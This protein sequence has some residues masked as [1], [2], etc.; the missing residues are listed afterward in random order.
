MKTTLIMF[1]L[2]LSSS[3]FISS[4]T[5]QYPL[6]TLHDINYVPDSTTGWPNSPWA[7]DTVR[8]Q[9]TVIVRPLIDSVTDR[10]TIMYAPHA[11]ESVIQTSDGSPW[12][13]LVIYQGDTNATATKFDLCDTARTYEFTG[14]VSP[15]PVSTELQLITAPT[16]IPVSLVSQQIKRPAPVTLTLDSCF[17]ADGSFNI[18]LRK[19]NNMYVQIVPDA[20]HPAIITSNLITNPIVSTAGGFN[21]DNG[22]GLMIQVY[23]QSRYF[24]TSPYYTIRPDYVPPPNGT[25]LSQISGLLQAYTNTWEI[26]P[27]YPNDL[28]NLLPPLPL[29]TN[30]KRNPGVVPQ[31][32]PATVSATVVSMGAVIQKVQLYYTVN[33]ILDSLI[34]IKGTGLDSTTWS[35]I[36]PGIAYDS[37]FVE[38]Y[39]KATDN[40]L[41]SQTSPGNISN[42]RY[43]YFILN[44]GKPFTI[45]HVRYSPFGSGQS[46]YNGY[47]V[48]VSG[49]VT[50][51]TSDIPGNNAPNPPR[52]FI[53]NGSNPWSGI[54]LGYKG[55]YGMNVL[56]L[57]QGDLVI[58][59]GTPVLA[60]TSGI[61]LD[62][63]T[64]LTVVSHNNP[65]PSAH[66][67][68][69]GT[70]GYS[71]LGTVAAEQ[72]NSCIV[73]YQTVTIDIANADG[74]YNYGESYCTDS[75]GGNHTRIIWSDGRTQFYAGPSAVV[76]NKG[77]NFA[78]ITGILGYSH[79][80]YK[81]CPRNN[82]DIV[83]Y[84][85]TSV[86]NDNY[87]IPNQY[88][89]Y[90]NFPNPFNPSTVIKYLIPY[91]SNVI[92]KVYNS[93]GQC[94][95]EF[96]AGTRQPGYNE[97]IFNSSDLASG[98]YFY[99][100]KAIS[101]NGKKDFS[102][103]KKMIVLK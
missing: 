42:N 66:I 13:G 74:I 77:D 41:L 38:Y 75:Y 20:N 70:V 1:L 44:P 43:S 37:A 22:N 25:R 46:G 3:G 47:P 15:F 23:A 86:K 11:F 49:V 79:S 99:S 63:L 65:L 103:V 19:Y 62:T 78:S 68:S 51:D 5:S 81:L 87:V 35:C 53:Q 39:V 4:Q 67:M 36:I 16:P 32:T 50:A 84:V 29:I 33:G 94:I 71:A 58:V 80:N 8:V 40:T 91:E 2:L 97:L 69:T 61:R 30:C 101:T 64:A 96:N 88:Q 21:I 28:N 54:S 95:R 76:V 34:M 14:V 83:G 6:V 92:I 52:V 100:I 82:N 55:A 85:P 56:D 90:Q 93:I 72:W 31:N 9:G 57:K 24:K 17:N 60:G 59:T 26:I 89:L 102:A 45:Q 10:R 18:K 12:S 48:T 7:G 73:T 98:I 27:L